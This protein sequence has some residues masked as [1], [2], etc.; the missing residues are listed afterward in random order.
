MK[1]ASGTTA[2]DHYRNI[3]YAKFGETPNLKVCAKYNQDVAG[4]INYRY[5]KGVDSNVKK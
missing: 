2:R 5:R 4:D 3:A 1:T